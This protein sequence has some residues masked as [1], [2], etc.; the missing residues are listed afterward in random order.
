MVVVEYAELGGYRLGGYYIVARE[1]LYVY[2]RVAAVLYRGEHVRAER[3]RNYHEP[4]EV[5]SAFN[6]SALVGEVITSFES[7]VRKADYP[8]RLGLVACY[9]LFGSLSFL[10]GHSAHRQNFFGTA[11]GIRH[12]LAV[13][14]DYRRHI[15]GFGRE[16]IAENLP[17]SVPDARI[18]N[19]RLV[20]G[21]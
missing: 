19:A 3:V 17:V 8:A 10:V 15:L 5:H 4:V 21:N 11:L 14:F 16:R 7:A 1:H 6:Q 9:R 20:R 12:F 2:A 13:L 18:F